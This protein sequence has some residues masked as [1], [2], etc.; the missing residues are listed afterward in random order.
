MIAALPMYDPPQLRT[1]T[2]ALWSAIRE[3]AAAEGLTPPHRLTRAPDLW[4]IWQAEDLFLAQA[5]GLPYRAH[6]HDRVTLVG[7]PDYGLAGLPPGHYR[8]VIVVRDSDRRTRPEELAGARLA[9]NDALSQS[10]WAAAHALGLSLRPV[11]QTG[12]HARSARAVADGRAEVAT[13][14]AVT[15]RIM[16]RH[17]P[18][19]ERLR[20]ISET[21]PT[22]GLPLITADPALA[23]PLRRAVHAAIAA[24]DPGLRAQLGITGLS[25]VPKEAYLAVPIPPSPEAVAAETG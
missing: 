6:L 24:L 3:G 20:V 2:D 25:V 16:E 1:A 9:Y 5:C 7:T 13:I 21:P 18:V 11:L 4:P 14:D 23:E 19:T 12:A 10:G 8:S 17:D 22:P 15:W